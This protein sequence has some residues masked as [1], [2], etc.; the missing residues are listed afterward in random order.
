MSTPVQEKTKHDH[1]LSNS[2]CLWLDRGM[3]L[4]GIL[5]RAITLELAAWVRRKAGEL[6]RPP[7]SAAAESTRSSPD[8]ISGTKASN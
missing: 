3:M 6:Q 7:Q 8:T 5:R 2:Q 1:V 4:G